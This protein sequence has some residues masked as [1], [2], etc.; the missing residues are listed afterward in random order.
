M[1]HSHAPSRSLS[2]LPNFARSLP[3][4]SVARTLL[5]TRWRTSLRSPSSCPRSRTT[6]VHPRRPALSRVRTL[7]VLCAIAHADRRPARAEPIQRTLLAAGPSYAEHARRAAKNLSFDA[8]D[9]HLAAEAAR[10]A[11]LAGPEAAE[12]D[13]GVGEEEESLAL[14]ELDPKEWKKQDHYAVLG[15]SALR[16]RATDE[17]IK[18]ARA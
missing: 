12:D 1:R 3:H 14:R 9:A 10:L 6:G 5:N 13:L 11:A 8:H 16:W 7:R 18:I 15:L 2:S 17:Q 4:A